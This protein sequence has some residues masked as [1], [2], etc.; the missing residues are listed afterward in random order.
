M[1]ESVRESAEHPAA[2]TMEASANLTALAKGL[3]MAQ[4][5]RAQHKP[6]QATVTVGAIELF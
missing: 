5:E 6:A 3:M 4:Q 2:D 1:L